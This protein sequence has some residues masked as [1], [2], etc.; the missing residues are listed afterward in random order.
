M[1]KKTKHI[2]SILVVCFFTLAIAGVMII[3][4]LPVKNP[5]G[6]VGNTAGNINN[7]GLFCEYNGLVYFANPYDGNA[8]Y[9]M[10]PD[11]KDFKKLGSVT[12]SLLNVGGKHIFYYQT[13]SNGSAG[14]G[15]LRTQT[16]IFRCDLKGNSTTNFSQDAAFS[17]QLV[18]NNLYY[19]V[20][21]DKGPHLYKRSINKSD[22]V[23]LADSII[24]PACVVD[25]KIYYNGTESNHYLYSLDTA[26]DSV[27][28][29]WEGN[30][31]DPIVYGNYVYYLDVANDYRLCRYSLT[32]GSI[33]ILTEDRIDKYNI[34]TNYIYYQKNS[35]TEPCLKRMFLDGSNP[36][37]IADGNFTDIN[38][39]S[40]YVYFHPFE[41]NVPTYRTPVD[42]AIQVTTFDAAAEAALKA[43]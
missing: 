26:T 14:L 3:R 29:V 20:S 15:Y 38:I 24:N 21:D 25:G 1:N 10:T 17:M 13:G 2:I 8:L 19:H 27:N 4:S 6:T 39:T 11:E 5:P 30:L 12:V 41:S 9:S 28:T 43:K 16:G 40:N 23:L 18:D 33:E 35:Q 36:E 37:I 42:G 7:K 32:E 31:W 22:P 34:S